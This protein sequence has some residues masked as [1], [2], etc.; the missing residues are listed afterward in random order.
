MIK[1]KDFWNYFCNN[2]EYRFF[3]GVPHIAFK[4]LYKK[5]NKSF[6]H[7]VP[8]VN[9]SAAMWLVNGVSLTGMNSAVIIS[10]YDLGNCINNTIKFNI[11]HDLPLVVLVN[12]PSLKE[13]IK[14][15]KDFIFNYKVKVVELSENFTDDLDLL[16]DTSNNLLSLLLVEEGMVI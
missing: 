10:I 3:S 8:A 5:M 12:K 4:Q 13:D 7:Y 1:A 15:V 14:F 16:S 11:E 2:L 6:L 9:A